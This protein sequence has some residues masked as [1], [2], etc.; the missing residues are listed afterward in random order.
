MNVQM[1]MGA[2]NCAQIEPNPQLIN[3][4][5]RGASQNAHERDLLDR[6]ENKLNQ[7]CGVLP[8]DT[9]NPT[10]V[11]AGDFVIG[12]LNAINDARHENLMRLEGML[13]RLSTLV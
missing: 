6:I 4:I 2:S 12:A 8:G 1:N 7:I 3:I 9:K 10:C 13:N 11:P 5:D